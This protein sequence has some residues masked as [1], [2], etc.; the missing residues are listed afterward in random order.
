MTRNVKEKTQTAPC[1][2]GVH[3]NGGSRTD[4]AN[5]ISA[6]RRQIP[7]H[8]R[9]SQ[10]D[11]APGSNQRKNPGMHSTPA[12]A[13]RHPGRP[14]TPPH[15]PR[16][17]L[18]SRRSGCPSSQPPPDH[19]IVPNSDNQGCQPGARKKRKFGILRPVHWK[20]SFTRTTRRSNPGST[21]STTHTPAPPPFPPSHVPTFQPYHG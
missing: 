18:A 8:S 19:A 13:H 2:I 5:C 1:R 21:G 12:A 6:C 7:L 16:A 9:I 3:P 15:R 20:P 17:R 11:T 4:N 10:P 14:A